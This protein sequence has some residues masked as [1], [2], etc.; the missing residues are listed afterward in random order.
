MCGYSSTREVTTRLNGEVERYQGQARRSSTLP[1]FSEPM[2][3][4]IHVDLNLEAIIQKGQSLSS[5]PDGSHDRQLQST[6]YKGTVE[7]VGDDRK[8]DGQRSV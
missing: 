7:N 5:F 1:D 2:R 4:T 8:D 6:L 3:M